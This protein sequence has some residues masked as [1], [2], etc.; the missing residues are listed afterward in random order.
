MDADVHVI[1][2]GPEEAVLEEQREGSEW[3]EVCR[4]PCEATVTAYPGAR[5]RIAHEGRHV[6][7]TI[8]GAEGES[9]RISYEPGA[10]GT[11][12]GLVVAGSITVADGGVLTVEPGIYLK[13]ASSAGLTVSNGGSLS[14]IGTALAPVVFT[15]SADD[16][17]G[18]DTDENG[19]FDVVSEAQGAHRS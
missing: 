1:A 6:R 14:A 12:T 3:T 7:L 17:W 9:V 2:R 19:T 13:M 5:N 8:R 11:R 15:S 16:R 4:L 10:R 18:G